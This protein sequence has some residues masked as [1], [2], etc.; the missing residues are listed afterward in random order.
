MSET[1]ERNTTLTYLEFS[2][3]FTQQEKWS[4]KQTLCLELTWKKDNEIG[5]EGGKALGK[6]LKFN[7]TLSRLQLSSLKMTR[8]K[9][10]I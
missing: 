7:T 5:G 8:C 1:L 3:L 10:V 2:S 4:N 6:M 9:S